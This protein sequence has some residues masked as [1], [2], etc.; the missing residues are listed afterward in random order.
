MSVVAVQSCSS[1]VA[2]TPGDG[3]SGW[4]KVNEN[5]EVVGPPMKV[6]SVVFSEV[7]L[8]IPSTF[9]FAVFNGSRFLGFGFLRSRSAIL[10]DGIG[11]NIQTRVTVIVDIWADFYLSKLTKQ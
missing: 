10:C 2:L 8:L 1:I 6:A 5:N 9:T 3:G 11:V 7:S 4:Q